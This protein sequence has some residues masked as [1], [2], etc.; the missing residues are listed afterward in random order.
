MIRLQYSSDR[1]QRGHISPNDSRKFGTLVH[2]QKLH[3]CIVIL[4]AYISTPQH[5]VHQEFH[6]FLF[7]GLDLLH[8]N[9]KI[10]SK[11]QHRSSV[12]VLCKGRM[13]LIFKLN[14]VTP[15]RTIMIL[16]I[17]V[18][19]RY[20]IRIHILVI[21]GQRSRYDSRNYKL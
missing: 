11:V 4:L 10:K 20:N 17:I 15:Q 1:T 5:L 2:V 8:L 6:N 7:N 14:Q 21:T 18:T 16:E 19:S 3:S 9:L 12:K 13:W